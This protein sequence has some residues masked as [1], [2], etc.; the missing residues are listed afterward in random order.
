MIGWTNISWLAIISCQLMLFVSVK[1]L[2]SPASYVNLPCIR[3]TP[4]TSGVVSSTT[5][6]QGNAAMYEQT[7]ISIKIHTYQF[8]VDAFQNKSVWKRWQDY[9]LTNLTEP[10]IHAYFFKHTL[11]Y[12]NDHATK[13]GLNW[14]EPSWIES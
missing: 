13:L 1:W 10:N 12:V 2:R 6:C 4:K 3:P 8:R 7:C 14:V 5:R 11:N 9:I